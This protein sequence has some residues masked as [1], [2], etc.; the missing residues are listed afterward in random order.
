MLV[1]ALVAVP[2]FAQVQ[3][4][5]FVK[6][7]FG[8]CDPGVMEKPLGNG[9]CSQPCGWGTV[10]LKGGGTFE[11]FI[12]QNSDGWVQVLINGTIPSDLRQNL[13][14]FE[15]GYGDGGQ[16]KTAVDTVTG[17]TWI[18]TGSYDY[19][20]DKD[21]C[22]NKLVIK[23]IVEQFKKAGLEYKPVEYAD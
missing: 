5:E 16:W 12:Y 18:G 4:S 17:Y 15:S 11:A 2:A 8:A 9:G 1:T 6:E 10:T 14:E 22:T 13:Q 23:K 3:K 21:R 20:C 7:C 19:L